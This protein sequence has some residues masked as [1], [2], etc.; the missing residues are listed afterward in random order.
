MGGN[1]TIIFYGEK[2]MS[3][4]K[5]KWITNEDTVVRIHPERIDRDE[6]EAIKSKITIQY[7]PLTVTAPIFCRSCQ[8]ATVAEKGRF[9]PACVIKTVN[10][11]KPFLPLPYSPTLFI[12]SMAAF[13]L[14][15][16]AMVLWLFQ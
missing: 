12:L 3:I 2:N 13:A 15:L 1:T 6:R 11:A 9:C 14:A 7:A 8:A 16:Y 10:E 5:A 4:A